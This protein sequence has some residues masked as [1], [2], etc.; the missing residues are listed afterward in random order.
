MRV[1]SL[2]AHLVIAI[3]SS[4]MH[5]SSIPRSR[6]RVFPIQF[7]AHD[8]LAAHPILFRFAIQ[9]KTPHMQFIAHVFSGVCQARGRLNSDLYV[10]IQHAKAYHPIWGGGNKAMPI[11]CSEWSKY[12]E[13]VGWPSKEVVY[14]GEPPCAIRF[15]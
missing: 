2:F 5:L 15:A 8:I 10:C 3:S 12:V 4:V 11:T 1:L 6:S 7:S 9:R 14:N 13:D